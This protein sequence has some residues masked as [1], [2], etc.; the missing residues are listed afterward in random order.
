M[1]NIFMMSERREHRQSLFY[2]DMSIMPLIGGY[3]EMAPS[4][5]LVYKD[6][7]SADKKLQWRPLSIKSYLGILNIKA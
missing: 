6:A 5:K 7:V 3:N 2:G 1:I 4:I